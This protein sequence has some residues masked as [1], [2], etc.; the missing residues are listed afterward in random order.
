M[1]ALRG[2]RQKLSHN[3]LLD[4]LNDMRRRQI[5]RLL[6]D[7]S[8]PIR[9]R[10]L[11]EQLVVDGGD[12]SIEDVAE[13]TIEGVR[14]QL[15]HAHLPRLDDAGLLDWA[16]GEETVAP[17]D[18]P[19]WDDPEFQRLIEMDGEEWDDVVGSMPDGRLRK[20][21]SILDSHGESVRRDVL[22]HRIAAHEADGESWADAVETVRSELHHVHLPKLEGA[23]LLEYDADNGTVNY[24]DI[25]SAEG[26]ER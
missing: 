4:C 13:V 23:G 10:E 26:W 8:E 5:L 1:N 21:L 3:E 9:E 12:K 19:I 17:T 16:E 18:D 24:Q 14:I 2:A 20:V 15:R 11:A 25:P 7:R 22:A 6:R